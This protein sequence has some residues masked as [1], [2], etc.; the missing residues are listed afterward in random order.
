MGGGG[1]TEESE[2]RFASF[3]IDLL[4]EEKQLY[5]KLKRNRTL[6]RPF[7]SLTVNKLLSSS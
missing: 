3:L 4:L 1:E 7:S 6:L 5:L 2:E